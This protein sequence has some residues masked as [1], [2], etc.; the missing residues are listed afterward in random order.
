MKPIERQKC[1]F[2]ESRTDT[3][4]GISGYTR[5]LFFSCGKVQTPDGYRMKMEATEQ[6]T[7]LDQSVCPY[8]IKAIEEEKG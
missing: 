8:A 3:W 7:L 5:H 6:C 4:H 1:D 2:C